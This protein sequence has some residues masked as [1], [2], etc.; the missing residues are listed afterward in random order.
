M[1]I[2]STNFPSQFLATIFI[3]LLNLTAIESNRGKCV[4]GQHNVINLKDIAEVSSPVRFY[5]V[6]LL[7]YDAAKKPFCVQGKGALSLPGFLRIHGGEAEIVRPLAP[8]SD[9]VRLEFTAEQDSFF[10]GSVCKDGKSVNSFVPDNICWYNFCEL[11][12]GDC[13]FLETAGRLSLTELLPQWI[14]VWPAISAQIEGEW[15][16]SV[17]LRTLDGKR[18]ASLGVPGWTHAKVGDHKAEK[19]FQAQPEVKTKVKVVPRTDE[20]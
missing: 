9:R 1:H 10:I 16:G 6:R 2:A 13:H 14:P 15:K 8:N 19:Q 3:F 12:G 18:I 20:L 7:T 5:N 4:D 11:I 17:S